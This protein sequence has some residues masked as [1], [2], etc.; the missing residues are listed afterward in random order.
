MPAILSNPVVRS[1]W[2]SSIHPKVEEII[3]QVDGWF[4]QHWPF[5]NEGARKKFVAAGF[6]RVTCLYFPRAHDERI[7]SACK[8]LTILF[9]IDDLLEE[10]SFVE[11]RAYNEHLMPI[12]EGKVAPDC[13]V[14]VEWMFHAIWEE[15]RQIDLELAESI[16]EPVFVFMH[17]Q[18]DKSRVSIDQL[19]TYLVYRERDVGSALLSALMRFSMNLKL[20]AKDLASMRSIEQNHAKHIAIVNDIYSWEKESRQAEKCAQ[21]GSALCSAV[22]IM[23]DNTGLDIES[24]K[25]VLWS[26]VREWEIKHETLC[27]A[28]YDSTDLLDSQALYVEGLKYQMSGNETWSKTTPRYS[29]LE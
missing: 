13:S 14:P 24:S 15:M 29:V 26:L 11:G 4:L 10:M 2:K 6:S 20:N 25:K 3:A 21:E 18:T 27:N 8:L 17:A 12:A 28:L 16:L 23:A 7:A 22:K 1:T 5:A 9:L 19:S